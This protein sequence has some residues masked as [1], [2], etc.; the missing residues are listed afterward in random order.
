MGR[1]I[2]VVVC[3]VVEIKICKTFTLLA[4]VVLYGFEAWSHILRA[5]RR[6]FG[7]RKWWD[8]GENCIMRSFI[9]GTCSTSGRH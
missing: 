3:W 9:G 7:G 5:L 4:V 6:I 2:Q 1:K 8:A